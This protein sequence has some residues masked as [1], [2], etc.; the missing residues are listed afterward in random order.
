MLPHSWRSAA[1]AITVLWLATLAAAGMIFL[2]QTL[3]ARRLGPS[4]YGLFASSLATVSMLAPLAGFG[5]SQFR[6]K[7]YGSEGWSAE[8]WL[9][10]ALRFSLLSTMLAWLLLAAWAWFAPGIDAAT[11]TA[12]WALLPVVV[13]L[14]AV[15]LVGSKLRL[16]ERHGALAA[17]QLLMPGGRLLVAM[18]AFAAVSVSATAVALGYGLVAALVAMLAA[19]QLWAMWRGRIELKG[20]GPRP[21]AASALDIPSVAQLSAQAWAYGLAAVLYPIFFQ[22]S[23]VLLKYLGSDAQAGHYGVALAIMTAVYLLPA[24]IYQKFLLSRLHRWAAHDQPKFW[25]VYRLGNRCM[26]AAGAAIGLTLAALAPWLVPALFGSAYAEVAAVLMV[27]AL[28]TPIRFLST[29]VGS[30]LLTAQHMRYRVLAMLAATA[31]AV[32]LNAAAVPHYGE[33]GAAWATV[34]AESLLLLSMWLGARRV[35]AK[36]VIA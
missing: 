1:A 22:I 33:L 2:S 14:L 26:A 32:A 19:P 12:L 3:L 5:L 27:L 10:P 4:D 16:E 11:R 20:H 17:W 21:E 9:R 24:T 36:A 18:L 28:C 7:A 6:L 35:M 15:D 34:I 13:G 25:R 23:T 29:S 30:V 8:R 31:A